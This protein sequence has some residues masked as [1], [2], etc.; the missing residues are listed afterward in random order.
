MVIQRQRMIATYI[1]QHRCLGSSDVPNKQSLNRALNPLQSSDP[2]DNEK[3]FG[4]H[5]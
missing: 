4:P 2:A 3:K 5:P 1:L